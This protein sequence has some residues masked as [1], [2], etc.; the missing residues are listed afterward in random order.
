MDYHEFRDWTGGHALARATPSPA[1]ENIAH[2]TAALE[3]I[4]RGEAM[5]P[6][7]CVA[8]TTSAPAVV[9]D[10]SQ[11]AV[12]NAYLPTPRPEPIFLGIS[13]AVAE[14]NFTRE[15]IFD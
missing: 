14:S 5:A 15:G 13:A 7:T 2:W 10:G 6:P 4:I 9:L 12:A 8:D 1:F 3:A 11:R